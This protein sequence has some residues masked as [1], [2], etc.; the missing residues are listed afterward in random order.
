MPLNFVQ[1]VLTPPLPGTD[2]NFINATTTLAGG[3]AATPIP[4]EVLKVLENGEMLLITSIGK[5]SPLLI[6]PVGSINITDQGEVDALT[7]TIG[8]KQVNDVQ[9]LRIQAAVNRYAAN[10]K[11]VITG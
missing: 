6:G 3:S 2:H 1:T 11:L 9:L 5:L 10:A 7:G 4:A 8:A